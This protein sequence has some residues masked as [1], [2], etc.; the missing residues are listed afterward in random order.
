MDTLQL[1]KYFR[2]ETSKKEEAEVQ[3]WLAGDKDGSRMR[4]YKEARILFEGTELHTEKV[5]GKRLTARRIIRYAMQAAAAVL[6]FIG[7]AS[8]SR[9]ST[10]KGLSSEFETIRVPAGKS[11]Q[12]VLADGTKMWINAAS[13]VEVPVIFSQQTRN[14]RV[15]EGE[16]FLEVAADRNKPF[17]VDTW[18]GEI[19]VLGTKFNVAVDA[20]KERFSTALLEGSIQFTGRESLNG[21]CILKPNE[22]LSIKGGVWTLNKMHSPDNANCWID[23]IIEFSGIPFEEVIDR[24]EKAFNVD[25]IIECEDM[26]E[27]NFNRGKIRVS[28]GIDHALSILATAAD[29]SY[30]RD[31]IANRIY[32]R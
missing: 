19:T 20:G 9:Y 25:I 14:I 24:F 5:Q 13:E 8:W 29:F 12:M 1:M 10:M 2:C 23:G 18:A 21:N 16:I 32:I 3:K 17:I 27:L 15:N 6:I 26:P 30:E 22:I 4:Q 11:M 28:E 7:A 31:I